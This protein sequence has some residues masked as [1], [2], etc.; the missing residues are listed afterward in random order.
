[1]YLNKK[2]FQKD[3]RD[4]IRREKVDLMITADTVHMTGVPPFDV[5]I[6]IVFDY[7]DGGQW[8]SSDPPVKPYITQSDA[9]LSVSAQA[10]EQARQFNSDVAYVPNGA[11]IERFRAASGKT[12]RNQFGLVDNTVVSLIGLVA[13][14]SHYYID[15]V[16][17]ARREIPN[18]RCLLVGKSEAVENSLAALPESDRDAFIYT[19]PVPY[20]KIASFFAASDVGIYPVDGTPYDDGRCP[21][22]IFEYTARGTPVVVPRLREVKRLDFNNIVYASPDA[23]SF[24]GGIIEAVERGPTPDPRVEKYD[25]SQIADQ[26]DQKLLSLT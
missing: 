9:I 4:I 22:K 1:M 5:E 20:D 11:D 8:K 10:T 17:E 19:G 21:M 26:L 16:R 6:P 7:L 23:S 3:I 13:S 25:W 12:V 14:D 18:L 15:A 24:A 2:F